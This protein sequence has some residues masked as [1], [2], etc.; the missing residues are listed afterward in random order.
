MQQ[1]GGA[2]Y[3]L[4]FERPIS[5]H[6]TTQ[7]YIGLAYHLSSRMQQHLT[8]RGARLT[9]VAKERGIGFVIAAIFPGDRNYE[10][11]LKRRKMGWRMCPICRQ[12]ARTR[13]QLALDLDPLDD[14]L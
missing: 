4:H 3:L 14:L 10:R 12:A 2:V 1:L 9:Q 7:H 5:E 8:G 13:N 6:H 11:L